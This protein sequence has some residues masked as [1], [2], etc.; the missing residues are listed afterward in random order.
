MRELTSLKLNHFSASD[1]IPATIENTMDA[2]TSGAVN[3]LYNDRKYNHPDL[4]IINLVKK[5][6]SRL[7]TENI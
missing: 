3:Q 4:I 1:G 6:D 7:E 2:A 5:K